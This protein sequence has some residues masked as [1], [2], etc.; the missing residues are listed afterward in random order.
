M[1]TQRTEAGRNQ[2]FYV[3]QYERRGVP[4]Y[5]SVWADS[6]FAHARDIEDDLRDTMFQGVVTDVM[7]LI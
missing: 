4:L 5:V 3:Y 7:H 6:T 1:T 2:K